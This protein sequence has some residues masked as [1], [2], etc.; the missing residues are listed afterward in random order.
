[1][2]SYDF[3]YKFVCENLDGV[4]TRGNQQ[5]VARCPLCGDSQKSAKK[6][7][8]GLKFITDKDIKFHCFNCGIK[9]NFYKL[10]A[11]IKN[12]TP[13]AAYRE[14]E[15]INGIWERGDYFK[16]DK[17]KEI[18]KPEVENFNWILK[19]C[20]RGHEN[21]II[22]EA[23]ITLLNDFRRKRQ[24]PTSIPL[25]ISVKGMYVG[26]IIIPVFD[27]DG[28]II[29]FQARATAEWQVPKYLNPTAEKS[30]IIP[31]IDKLKS[32]AIVTEGL[33]DS[34]SLGCHGTCSLGVEISNSFIKLLFNK[35]NS[36][37]IATD[38]DIA[39]KEAMYKFIE[40]NEYSRKVNYFIMPDKY[41]HIK[42]LNQLQ[43]EQKNIN[44]TDFVIKNTYSY[45]DVL[46][47]R[48]NK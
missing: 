4:K 10:Y 3:V 46:V 36:I 19:S 42:D 12:I 23:Y 24:I 7:R 22:N 45:V 43:I 47:K 17:E 48:G 2:P 9:G 32:P 8:F 41:Q 11:L 44:I 14:C 16:V 21:G 15:S 25:Y 1:M 28:D 20:I 40:N 34:F 37:I 26:R 5:I 30:I 18:V 39:G 29:Y 35:V 13:S 27:I 38:N 33:I 31:N 6:R